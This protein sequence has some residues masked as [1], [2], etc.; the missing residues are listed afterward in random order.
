[1]AEL[2][3]GAEAEAAYRRV[4][5]RRPKEPRALNNLG[6]LLARRGELREAAA[7]FEQALERDERPGGAH[8]NLA[9][10]CEAL[11]ERGRAREHYARALEWLPGNREAQRSLRRLDR[12]AL[13]ADDAPAAADGPR[14][15]R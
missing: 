13:P 8:L 10:A 4:L 7:L 6:V 2:A 3:R 12:A 14:A 15:P 11:G 1:M 5:E 9:R